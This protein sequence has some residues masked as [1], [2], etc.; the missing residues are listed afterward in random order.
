MTAGLIGIIIL[1]CLMFFLELP[2]GLAMGMVGLG[3]LWYMLT[4]DAALAMVGNEIWNVF[5]KY[6]LTVIPM[7][8]L[9]GQI[10]FYSGVNKNLYD[11]AHTWMGRTRGGL[12]MA[13]IMACAG[14]AAIC[15]SNTAT[16]ATMTAVA[17]P[18]MKKREYHPILSTSSIAVG[19]TLG[20]VIPPSVV[21]I[22]YGI[23]TEQSIGKL[24]WGSTIPGVLLAVLFCVTTYIVCSIH[25]QWGPAGEKT[26]MWQKVKALPGAFEMFVLFTLIM[27]GLYSGTYTPTEAGAAGALFAVVLGVIRRK[28]TF[29]GF[30]ASVMDTL[31][32]SCM[33]IL[34]VT[35]AVIL[36]RFLT[37]S[38]MPFEVADYVSSLPVQ[39]WVIII[40]IL[41][42]YTIA[43]MVMDALGF[44]LV[45]IPIFFPVVTK[46]GYD[47]I[48]FGCIICVVTTLGAVT[49]PVG[50][51]AYVV[52]G[53]D[54]DIQ[55]GTVLKGV[56]W[57]LPA[58]WITLLLMLFYPQ[59]ALFLPSFVK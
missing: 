28:L 12:A 2:V 41:V 36:G 13:T 19:S 22:V 9:M 30:V 52:A 17:L 1:L 53:M 59:L 20:V 58:Y 6:G 8:I 34:I 50:I 49:P 42:I 15:G 39:P 40:A 45:S 56:T 18:E 21:L 35:G 31:K 38:R 3:G 10:C 57:F 43:G 32:V 23:Y 5:P 33:I 11:T 47:P 27:V 25:P 24:F 51:C 44:L 16:A 29:K 54:K 4:P 48:W 46:M 14:F 7:F 55:L 26:T 37:I